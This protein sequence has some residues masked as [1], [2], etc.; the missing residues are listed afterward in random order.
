M[1]GQN[2][3]S[4]KNGGEATHSRGDDIF[5]GDQK[6]MSDFPFLIPNGCLRT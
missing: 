5:A 3:Q 2:L 4:A 6:I 1:L